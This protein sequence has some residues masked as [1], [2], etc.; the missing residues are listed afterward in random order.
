[1]QL[2]TGLATDIADDKA[3]EDI[4]ALSGQQADAVHL[5]TIQIASLQEAIEAIK[6]TGQ[7]RI[8]QHMERYCYTEEATTTYFLRDTSR[9]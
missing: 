3:S 5:N 9:R 6:D 1:M 7:I 8:V 2:V 4:V